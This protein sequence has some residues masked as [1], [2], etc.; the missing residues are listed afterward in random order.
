MDPSPQ[1]E[2]VY[3]G[4]L[5]QSLPGGASEAGSA[6]QIT[7]AAERGAAARPPS[8]APAAA[9]HAP[10][11][12]F[13]DRDEQMARV[14]DLAG[15]ARLVTL[16]GPG[17][18][19]KTRLAA[20]VAGRLAAQHRGVWLVE[21]APLSQPGDVP[22]TALTALGIRDAG[23]PEFGRRTPKVT[24]VLFL[25]FRISLLELFEQPFRRRGVLSA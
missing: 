6:R 23:L 10:L 7:N 12:S 14:A 3:L 17:G 2:Q 13:V 20:E 5:R 11:T 22:Y 16:T 25:L 24:I 18:V 15:Q 19:G 1:L 8:T 4:V 9:P 21:L